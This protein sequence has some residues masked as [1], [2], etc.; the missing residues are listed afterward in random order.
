MKFLTPEQSKFYDDN[1]YIVLDI[2]TREEISELSQEYDKI[3]QAKA[4]SDLEATWDGDWKQ[5]EQ[6]KVSFVDKE[7][8]VVAFYLTFHMVLTYVNFEL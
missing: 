7:I 1:G 3:F 2:L 8:L 6:K 5:D 4:Q